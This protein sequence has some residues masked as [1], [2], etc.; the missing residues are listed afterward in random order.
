[1][2][3]GA[4]PS[5]VRRAFL[6]RLGFR[7]D[8]F[9]TEAFDLLE[10]GRNVIVAAP[11][12]AGKTLVADY[13]VALTLAAGQRIFYTTP[14]KALSNQKFHDLVG[15]HGAGRVGLLTGDNAINPEAAVVVMTTEVLRN[16]LYAGNRLEGLGVVVLDEV[17]YLQDAYRGPVWEE[18]IIHLPRRIQLLCLSATVSNAEELAEWIETVRG[19][20]GLVRESR[21]PVDLDHLYLVGERTSSHLNLIQVARG[22]KPNPNG[23]RYDADVRQLAGGR[24]P[25]NRRAGKPRPKWRTPTRLEVV[26]LLQQRELLPMIYFI[27]SRA[28]CD[29]ATSSVVRSGLVLTSGAEQ[30]LIRSILADRME[31][32]TPDDREVLD[33]ERFRAGLEAGVAPH[34]AGMVPPFKEAVEACFVRGLVKV[35]FATE[36]L[37]LG[38]NMP[39]R[40]VVVEKLTKFTGDHH[41]FL[42]PAQYTQLTGRAGRRGIDTQGKAVVLWSPFVRFEQVSDLAL[43]RDFV[44]TSSFRPTYNMAANLVRRYDPERARQLLNLSFAQFRADAG[45]VRTEQQ[46]ERLME[47]R[48]QIRRRIEAEFAPVDD[49]R[50]ALRLGAPDSGDDRHAIAFALSQLVPGQVIE[51][52]GPALSP[53]VVVLAVSFRSGGRVK[54]RVVDREGQAQEIGPSDLDEVPVVVGQVSLPEPYLPNSVTFAYEASQLLARTRLLAPKR[55]RALGP[56]SAIRSVDDVPPQARK[57]L[58]R[59]ERLES[60]LELR[61]GAAARRADSLAGQFDRVIALLESR[62]HLTIDASGRRPSSGNDGDPDRQPGWAL[63]PSGQRLARLYHE[64]DLLVVEALQDGLFEGLDPA[65]VAALAS[66]FAYEERRAGPLGSQPRFPSERLRRRFVRLE[67]LH[68][69][70]VADETDAR[71]ALT[72]APDAGFMA[73]AQAWAFGGDLGDVLADEAITAG[74]FV[75]TAKQLIDLLRQLGILAMVP[76]TANAARSAAEAMFRDLVAVSSLVAP[77]G[78]DPVDQPDRPDTPEPTGGAPVGAGDRGGEAL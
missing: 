33:F 27:F 8:E 60:D 34:H 25:G 38:V 9:Q 45:V 40:T 66:C 74:D 12:G 2:E 69:A 15:A 24:G 64:C 75:R 62:G 58:R 7:P 50:A 49:L 37:A 61:P 26:E 59:L 46:A 44:L 17:H 29:E 68:L 53:I 30:R 56:A 11:T 3:Q 76:A 77:T 22:S 73:M 51:V 6:G 55:R 52:G 10:D 4:A 14:I 78:P 1:M 71:L 70:L 65:D 63:T 19:Q 21:R 41:E 20:T 18:V 57:L 31:G 28:A 42:T 36:T 32:F 54:A 13:A 72:R 67:G 47:R 48:D 43:S 23:Y 39:A 5:A 35:V 16:M